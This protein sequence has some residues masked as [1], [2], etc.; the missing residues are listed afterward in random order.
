MST[1]ND[2]VFT[3]KGKSVSMPVTKG[4]PKD[5]STEALRRF[6]VLG[7]AVAGFTG[8]AGKMPPSVAA[9]GGAGGPARSRSPSP[10][11]AA[12]R[13]VKPEKDG[14]LSIKLGDIIYFEPWNK[15]SETDSR[16]R[17]SSIQSMITKILPRG[18]FEASEV[19]YLPGT[20]FDKVTFKVTSDSPYELLK[21]DGH[22]I[23]DIFEY[24]KTKDWLVDKSG[25]NLVSQID[26]EPASK[27][28]RM[29]QFK[30]IEKVEKKNKKK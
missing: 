25:H 15:R 12:K 8:A 22:V 27:E 19:K 13:A 11:P 29:E 4:L 1:I 26:G 9:M 7:S 10:K 3:V 2:V 16:V 20:K 30:R 21:E 14:K 18:K 23:T 6:K 28:Q 17:D 24:N 5:V